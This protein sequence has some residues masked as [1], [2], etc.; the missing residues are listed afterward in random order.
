MEAETV[1]ADDGTAEEKMYDV[2]N[3]IID[4]EGELSE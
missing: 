4:A 3:K 1:G 2:E